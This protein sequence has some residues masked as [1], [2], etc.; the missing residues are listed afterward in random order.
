MKGLE[1]LPGVQDLEG[2]YNQILLAQRSANGEVDL[3]SFVL[4]CQWSRF[5]SRMGE[6]CVAFLARYWKKINPVELHDGFAQQPWPAV[7]GVLLEFCSDKSSLFQLW[8]K[9]ATCDFAKANWEQ[10]FIGRRRVGGQLMF[11]DS[12]FSLEE[13]RK[14]GYLGREILMNKQGR[15]EGQENRVSYSYET[16]VQILKDFLDTHRRVTT[17]QYW[18]AI[19]KCVSR[20]QAERDLQ[21]SGLLRSLGRTKGRYFVKR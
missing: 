2:G 11:D 20:R 10:F 1:K 17:Q 6:I 19:H 8:K 5:D 12:R 14:W 7:L 4:F 16:R 15:V 3:N 13:Y 21:S 9:T 18:E